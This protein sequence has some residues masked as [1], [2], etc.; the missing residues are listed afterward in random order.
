MFVANCVVQVSIVLFVEKKFE[1]VNKNF[2][3]KNLEEGVG[4]FE[5]RGRSFW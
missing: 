5:S 1:S 4:W 2:G 3:T